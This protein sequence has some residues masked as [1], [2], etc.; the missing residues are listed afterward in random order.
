MDS[1]K[2]LVFSD[3]HGNTT[4]LKA[5]F[6]WAK[7]RTLP[8]D[9]ICAAA[10]LGDGINDLQYAADA[11]GFDCNWIQVR[12]NNDYGIQ[13][14]DTRIFNFVNYRFFICHGHHYSLYG[15][16]H[17]LVSAA[18]Y[19]D[20]NVVLFGHTHVPY[21][22]TLNGVHLINPGCISHPRSSTGATFAVIECAEGKQLKV[23]FFG[24]GE[25]NVIKK[26]K[27]IKK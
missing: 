27:A 25:K 19:N 9:S 12:G 10:F 21:H 24:I 22:K 13:E 11:T 18:R 7:E 17:P 26:V 16:Y 4:A 2:L 14:S 23:E 3:T 5:V 15:G 8:N 20:A 6:N 1:K